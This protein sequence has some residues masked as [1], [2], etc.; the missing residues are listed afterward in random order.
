M[1]DSVLIKNNAT[2][3][4][5]AGT[6]AGG[7]ISIQTNDFR[8]DN[9]SLTAEAVD[10]ANGGNITINSP[11]GTV[12][13]SDG[14]IFSN[15]AQAGG[16]NVAIEATSIR[17]EGNSDIRTNVETGSGDG[18]NISLS[19]NSIIFFDDSDIFAFARDGNGGNIN[20]RTPGFFGEGYTAASLA[21]SPDELN[22]NNRV[23]L[24]A[25]G[26]VNG[27]GIVTDV[28]FLENSLTTLPDTLIV[29]EQ[30]ISSSCIARSD[31]GQVR[32]S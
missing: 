15:S 19:A 6:G 24:N 9:S 11:G 3:S 17:F 22:G 23:D 4:S 8:L 2:V 10:N 18:G 29:P 21:A 12:S 31:D 1:A 5:L 13:T 26:S 25:T 7:N 20:L 14:N 32:S 28:S 16:G 30:L 27:I